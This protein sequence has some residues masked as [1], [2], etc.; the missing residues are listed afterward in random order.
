LRQHCRFQRF[1]CYLHVSY[2][3]LISERSYPA[4]SISM[5][6]M[7]L[8]CLLRLRCCNFWWLNTL[9]FLLHVQL[10][11][12]NYCNLFMCCGQLIIR[13]HWS[14]VRIWTPEDETTM[15]SRNVGN[16]IPTDA[17]SRSRI[18]IPV[19]NG[20]HQSPILGAPPHLLSDKTY[21]SEHTPWY[22]RLSCWWSTE[23]ISHLP[24]IPSSLSCINTYRI[25]RKYRPLPAA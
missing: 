14:I 17:A 9:L 16:Q 20:F 2:D 5:I 13:V 19:F 1:I 23:C 11:S 12:R 7:F 3:P 24:Q 22:Y 18:N 25:C 6:L 15:L 4:S 8:V 10:V 21:I